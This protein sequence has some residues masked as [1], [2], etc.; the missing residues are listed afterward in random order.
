MGRGIAECAARAGYEVFLWGRRAGAADEAIEVVGRG[1]ERLVAKEKLDSAERDAIVARLY[2]IDDMA[3]LGSC[4]LVIESIVEAMEP[5]RALFAELGSICAP[6]T[7]LATNTSTLPIGDL[8]MSTGRPAN[9]CGLHFFNP[10]P[11]SPVIEV[12]AGAETSTATMET[13]RRFVESLGK[14]AIEVSDAHGFVV[15]ALLFPYLNHAIELLEQG[16]ASRED[17]DAVMRGAC[18]FPLGPFELLDLVGLDTSLAI[19]ETLHAAGTPGA[20]PAAMLRRL[21]AEGH[22]GRKTGRGFIDHSTS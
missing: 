18:A 7:I 14:A 22:L 16:R 20:E 6:Q 11:T 2:G 17:M 9:F 21:V 3:K 1:L 8:A 15:N 4:D 19:L 5:K 10:A 13:A 12:I